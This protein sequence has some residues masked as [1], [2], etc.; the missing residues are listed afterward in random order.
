MAEPDGV[1]AH[2]PKLGLETIGQHAIVI[3]EKRDKFSAGVSDADISSNGDPALAL[4]DDGY[5]FIA[6]LDVGKVVPATIQHDDELP[7]LERLRLH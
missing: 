3:V 6:S 5:P 4:A 2:R 7:V 1:I